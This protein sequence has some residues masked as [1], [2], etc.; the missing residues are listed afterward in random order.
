MV[1]TVVAIQGNQVLL[2]GD[3]GQTVTIQVDPSTRVMRAV[4]GQKSLA[5]APTIQ[6]SDIHPGDRMLASGNSTEVGGSITARTIVIVSANDLAQRRSEEQKSWQSG[7]RGVVTHVDPGNRTITVK[8]AREASTTI[9][10]PSSASLLRY[11]DGSNKFSEA[12]PAKIEQVKAGDQLQAKGSS[13]ASGNFIANA[14]LFGTFVNVAGRI[15]SVDAATKAVTVNDVFTKKPVTLKITQDSLMRQLPAMI[16]QRIAMALQ[17]S[18]QTLSESGRPAR[19]VDFQQVIA[20]SP[21]I[22][23]NDLHKGDAVI[24]VAGSASAQNPAF[25]LIDGIEPILTSSPAGSGAAALLASWN[26]ST[27]GEGE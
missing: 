2:K 25:Y 6:L 11:S 3:Q 7:P 15:Q 21:S 23:L 24:A 27:G 1:G 13:D 14:V 18:D 4:P 9:E 20:H 8:S 22:G 5:D 26:L 17:R 12:Q 10:V 16:A 19:P